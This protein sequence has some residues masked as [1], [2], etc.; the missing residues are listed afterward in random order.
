MDAL[1]PLL[2]KSQD[3]P[4]FV[5]IGPA[6]LWLGQP[7][8]PSVQIPALASPRGMC[9][10]WRRTSCLWLVCFWLSL[11]VL[12]VIISVPF[13]RLSSLTRLLIF[14]CSLKLPPWDFKKKWEMVSYS[15]RVSSIQFFLPFSHAT[16]NKVDT[17]PA[18]RSFGWK[19][20]EVE[21]L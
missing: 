4:L 7:G 3:Q 12:P 16:I 20:P 10:P 11:S 9:G 2:L 6:G 18:S 19:M 15:L 1:F 13:T 17:A 8:T 5:P 21:G 14:H